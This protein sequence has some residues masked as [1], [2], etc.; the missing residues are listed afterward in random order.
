MVFLTNLQLQKEQALAEGYQAGPLPQLNPVNVS[1]QD[2][3]GNAIILVPPSLVPPY[4]PL[5]ASTPNLELTLQDMSPNVAE[6]FSLIDSFVG[7]SVSE[8]GM[9]GFQ[10]FS[11]VGSIQDHALGFAAYAGSGST[12]TDNA[13]GYARFFVVAPSS[14]SYING[15]ISDGAA[16]TDP[17]G[18][19]AIYTADGQ[20]KLTE[21][22]FTIATSAVGVFSALW[23]NAPVFLPQG[24]YILAWSAC[25]ENTP[26]QAKV[27]AINCGNYTK[28]VNATAK[29]VGT[30]AK[31][32]GAPDYLFPAALG[33]LT[34]NNN[35]TLLP[36]L[37]F[38]L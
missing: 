10:P 33:T 12:Y 36:F 6:N 16:G 7:G 27:E 1:T 11:V 15:F 4:Y 35:M 21:T 38:E 22:K 28:M 23:T 26:G 2:A 5:T 3:S 37:F 8:V 34:A 17:I 31:T 18:K 9:G 32:I 24:E 29:N 14:I 25:G 19:F 30:S 20:T 13:I